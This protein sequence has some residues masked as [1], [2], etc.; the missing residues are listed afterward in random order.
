MN[1]IVYNRCQRIDYDIWAAR[2]FMPLIEE[3][4]PKV[5]SRNHFRAGFESVSRK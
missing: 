2:L 3:L 1:G 4:P 5:R